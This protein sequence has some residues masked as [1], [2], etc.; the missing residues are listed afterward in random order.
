[1]P[2]HALPFSKR[3]LKE[4]L[5]QKYQV[6]GIPTLVVLD[7]EGNLVTPNG[8]ADYQKYLGAQL[9]VAQGAG[10]EQPSANTALLELFGE[11]LISKVG[12][13]STK[14][15]VVGKKHVMIYFSAHWCPPC[16]GFTPQLAKAYTGSS[17]A[18]KDAVVIFVS[19]DR[20]QA[21]FDDYYKDM[22]WHALPF[23]K[24]DLK[25]K[26]SQKYQVRGIPTLVVLDG[27]GNLVTTNGRAEYQKY[28][29][30]QGAPEKECCTIS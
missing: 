10:Q 18:G 4:K 14:D 15:V 7:G 2:W 16:R 25:E 21:G 12:E 1:M 11:T 9:G 17:M 28:L 3:D 26:L 13:V 24:R 23:S 30:V 29:G 20:D 27:E 8:R 22:P 5:S 19:S 6:R